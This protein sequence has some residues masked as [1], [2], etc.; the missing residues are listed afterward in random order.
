MTFLFSVLL[1]MA[2]ANQIALPKSEYSLEDRSASICGTHHPLIIDLGA[3]S[4]QWSPL[5]AESRFK[6]L[7]VAIKVSSP[8]LEEINIRRNFSNE[9]LNCIVF[10]RTGSDEVILTADQ[11]YWTFKNNIILGSLLPEDE[12]LVLP[13]NGLGSIEVYGLLLNPGQ[14]DQPLS[15]TT[16]FQFF[17]KGQNPLPS[18]N[19]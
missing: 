13:I 16:Q 18:L 4:F 17:L 10:N 7:F 19:P 14:P 8:G 15:V 3:P 5:N 1:G 6:I 2:T 12:D 11:S 9:L